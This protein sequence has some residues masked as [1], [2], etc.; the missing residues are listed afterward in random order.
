MSSLS[1]RYLAA[2]RDP[3]LVVLEGFHPLK[4]AWLQGAKVLAVHTCSHDE[5]LRTSQSLSPTLTE[6]FAK[7][8]QPL[9]TAQFKILSPDYIKT[10]VIALARK[11]V[12]SLEEILARPGQIVY[13]EQVRNLNNLGAIVR[14]LA[15]RGVAG[16]LY[17][18][19][20]N[21]WHPR[22]VSTA[23]G[24][25][26]A[27][28][29]VR[30]P[31]LPVITGRTLIGFDERGELLD[32]VALPSNAVLAFGSERSGLRAPTR[33]RLDRAVRIPMQVNV[34]SLNLATAVAIGVYR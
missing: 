1:Q 15:A 25:Q 17:S 20:L 4:H 14:T 8:M 31:E 23:R 33:E 5:V 18:G 27:L 28:P 30:V 26:L 12:Y 9:P 34:S 10:G 19:T 6:R 7:E 13:L 32:E 24:L 3:G 16:L 21:V 22:C 11:P 29:V 2:R